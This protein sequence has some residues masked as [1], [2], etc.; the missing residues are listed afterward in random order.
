MIWSSNV[1]TV[2]DLFFIRFSPQ[3]P[4]DGP[5]TILPKYK[6][7]TDI[8]ILVIPLSPQSSKQKNMKNQK[9]NRN[10]KVHSALPR[11]WISWELILIM[12]KSGR[13]NDHQNATQGAKTRNE[14]MQSKFTKWESS[15]WYNRKEEWVGCAPKMG[16][17]FYM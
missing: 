1:C 3:V 7:S 16:A 4:C 13:I 9:K 8:V 10:W 11:R 17:Q 12:K 5:A 6:L 14:S 2:Q 15:E